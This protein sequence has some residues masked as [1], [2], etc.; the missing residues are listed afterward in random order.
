MA[1]VVVDQNLPVPVH[2]HKALGPRNHP[3]GQLP[4]TWSVQGIDAAGDD[5]IGMVAIH[6]QGP[7]QGPVV[8]HQIV[9]SCPSPSMSK[10]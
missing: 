3:D 8:I 2:Q 9:S 6:R 7:Q 10:V 4:F 5:L 1:D